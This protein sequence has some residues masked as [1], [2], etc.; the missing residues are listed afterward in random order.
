VDGSDT[1]PDRCRPGWDSRYFFP[2][3]LFL[4]F[5]LFLATRITRFRLGQVN[6]MLTRKCQRIIDL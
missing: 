3:L 2:F 6:D 1:S 4:L 5:L